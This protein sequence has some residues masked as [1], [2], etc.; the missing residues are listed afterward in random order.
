[1]ALLDEDAL[2]ADRGAV[3]AGAAVP[4]AVGGGGA[5]VAAA[6]ERALKKPAREPETAAR[7]RLS[8][9]RAPARF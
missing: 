8:L 9:E 7:Q 2:A 1:M 5:A 6:R 4:G 3:R